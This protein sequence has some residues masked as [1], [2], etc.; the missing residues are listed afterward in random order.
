MAFSGAPS[1]FVGDRTFN[2]PGSLSFRRQALAKL[3][4]PHVSHSESPPPCAIRRLLDCG[5][6]IL[7]QF[8]AIHSRPADSDIRLTSFL[9]I[10]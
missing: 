6:R 10:G 5:P 9:R 1:F 4:H 7:R 2:R 3:T 8:L